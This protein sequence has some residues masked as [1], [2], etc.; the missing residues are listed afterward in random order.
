MH[1]CSYEGSQKPLF[2]ICYSYFVVY[3][4][5]ASSRLW[6]LLLSLPF[7]ST[8]NMEKHNPHQFILKYTP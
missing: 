8:K 7:L 6:P 1:F 4:P 5:K 2:L 3:I